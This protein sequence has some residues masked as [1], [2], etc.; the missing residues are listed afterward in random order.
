MID[1]ALS[2][3]QVLGAALATVA[4]AGASSCAGEEQSSGDG[5]SGRPSA[6]REQTLSIS[7]QATPNSFDPAEL[8]SSQSSFAWSALFDTLILKDN[9]GKL[10]PN[11]AESWNYSDS[12]R[13]LTL[14]LR[15]GMSFS[16][17]APVNAVAV[18]TTL[19]RSKNTPGSASQVLGAL[20][21][22]DAPDDRTVVLRL[23]HPD[24]ALLDSLAVSGAGVI[25]DPATLND[26]RTALNPVGSGPYVLNTGQ[27]VNGSTYVLDRR[28]DYWNVQAYPFKTVKISVIR[29]RTAALNAL[30]AGEVNAGTVEVTNVD[31]LRAA[32]FDAAVVEANS[33]ASLV[34]ADRA[35][36]SLKPLGDPRVRQ[37]INMAFDRE[38][39]VEQLLRGSGKPTE[40]VFNPKD[41]AYDPAL[42]TT[43]AYDPQRAKRLLA[44]AGYPNG[45]S[46]TM[47]EFFLAKS[48]APTITQS[49]AAIGI[50]VT[51]EPVPPQ[52]TD[53]AISSKK[54]PAFF[55]IAGLG[56]TAQ[57]ASTYFSKDGAY[58][59]FHTED[60][61]LTPQMEQAAQT[62][63]PRQAADAYRHVNATAVREAWNAPLFYVAVHWVTK[64]GITYL[65]DG[66]LTFNTVR[67]FGLS[68]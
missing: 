44:E 30:Q 50:A 52:Q 40:Q 54:Y 18:K 64:K 60:P 58:N 11:A 55:T 25:G 7:I 65:G 6:S 67:A 48:F 49:L 59:P 32:G 26:K 56:T 41:P 22:V 66:S 12:G 51:W 1:G 9:K 8:I 4:V 21:S 28:E 47:P 14:K 33:L 24:G 17:G 38:K 62:I 35:G 68:G 36:E 34:L 45:F 61:D 46:V 5:G 15:K 27:T 29:D 63:D 10:Q 37:A 42:N 13:T 53:A 23:S 20:E 57:D 31:R 3:R 43:Y 16:S 19:E 2:R 39:I